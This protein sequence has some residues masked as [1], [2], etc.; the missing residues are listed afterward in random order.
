ME[1]GRDTGRGGS[2]PMWVLIPGSHPEPKA[3]VQPQSHPGVPQSKDLRKKA[4]V[5]KEPRMRMH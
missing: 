2:S 4:A 3:D 1:R 5:E